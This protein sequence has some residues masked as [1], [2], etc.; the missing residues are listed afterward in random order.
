MHEV[1]KEKNYFKTIIEP[2]HL[3]SIFYVKPKY[4]NQRMH[5]QKGAFLLFGMNKDNIEEA[6]P[7]LSLPEKNNGFSINATLPPT[8]HPI[9]K[10]TKFVLSCEITLSML[11]S[12][13]ITTPYI[14]PEM[15]QVAKYLREFGGHLT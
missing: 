7:L 10:I 5:G 2:S 4:T 3:F 1:C 6:I 14:Y 15:D 12:L 8:R 13:G 11:A 9:R